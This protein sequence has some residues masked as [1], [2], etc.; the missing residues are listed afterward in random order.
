MRSEPH[1]CC[2]AGSC[3]RGLPVLLAGEGSITGPANYWIRTPSSSSALIERIEKDPDLTVVVFRIEKPGYF[4]PHWGF[5]ADNDRVVNMAPGPT[6]LHP[7]LDNF[8]RRSRL[9]VATISEIRGR[10]RGA[11]SEFI[12]ATDISFASERAVLGQFDGVCAMP[13]LGCR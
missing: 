9:P 3:Q 11:G 13:E 4:T 8:V 7:Y 12:L 5:L 10:T 1:G 2:R 6:G